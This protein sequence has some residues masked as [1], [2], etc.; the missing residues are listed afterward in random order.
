MPIRLFGCE[1]AVRKP[2]FLVLAFFAVSA[3]AIADDYDDGVAAHGKE[4]YATA[5]ARF[6]DAAEQGNDR[7]QYALGTMYHDGDGVP[8]D[9]EAAAYWY[10]KAAQRGN[11]QAQQ[12]LCIMHREAMGVPRD[13]AESLYWCHRAADKGSSAAQFSVGQYYFDGLGYGFKR[14][15]VR[16]YIWF[17]RA[18][19]Q[20]YEDARYMI[21]R[22]ED[23]MTPLEVDEAKRLAR[24]WQ[25]RQ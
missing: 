9:H 10:T 25:P 23:E 13:Y 20:G 7:A 18:S 3:T 8:R 1:M 22:L 16:A 21:E 15:Y 24:D 11:I 4:D 17:S 6:T 2:V 12:W 5:I 19:S 14:D